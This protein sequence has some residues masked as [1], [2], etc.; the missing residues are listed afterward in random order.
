MEGCIP[1]SDQ[2]GDGADDRSDRHGLSR[3][4]RRDRAGSIC[5]CNRILYGPVH[6]RLRIQPRCTDN[7]RQTKRRR[8]FRRD[9]KGVLE[10]D[11]FPAGAF[12]A[13]HPWFRTADSVADEAHGILGCNIYSSTELCQM[14]S[15]RHGLR[16]H[17]SNVPCILCGHYPD[18]DTDT[19]LSGHGGVKY[20]IQLDTDFRKVRPPG[21]GNHRSGD[22]I[23]P[24]RT[25]LADIL[26]ALH[27]SKMRP[28][29]IWTGKGCS[30]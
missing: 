28:Q 20:R 16:L 23:K 9:W 8:P 30:I 19:E 3:E 18:Q 15:A 14:A 6:D 26:H 10:R 13:D 24:C 4:G 12:R 1:D 25:R 7:N 29:E 22:R 27:K 5:H 21:S 17:D 11:I 2:S